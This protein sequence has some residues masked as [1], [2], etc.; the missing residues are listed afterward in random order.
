M[1]KIRL[2]ICSLVLA[3]VMFCTSLESVSGADE[4]Q[5]ETSAEKITVSSIE[6]LVERYGSTDADQKTVTIYIPQEDTVYVTNVLR[7]SAQFTPG[8]TYC[9]TGG[10]VLKQDESNWNRPMISLSGALG[11]GLRLEL[12]NI[13][14]DGGNVPMSGTET[15]LITI[16]GYD[17]CVTMEQDAGARTEIRNFNG[18]STDSSAVCAPVIAEYGAEF[19]LNGGTI[20]DNTAVGE[21]GYASGGVLLK[22]YGLGNYPNNTKF[23]M[24]GGVIKD[25]HGIYGA[26]CV[27]FPH[28]T[29]TMNGGSICDNTSR[30]GGGIYYDG[31]EEYTNALP[32]PYTVK[33]H[34]NASMVLNS[35]TISGNQAAV[36]GNSIYYKYGDPI[37]LGGDMQIS[38]DVYLASGDVTEQYF[39]LTDTLAYPLFLTYMASASYVYDGR[40]IARGDGSYVPTPSDADQFNLSNEGFAPEYD[41][42]DFCIKLKKKICSVTWDVEGTVTAETYEYAARPKYGGS[43]EKRAD[44]EYVY[45]FTG[46]KNGDGLFYGTDTVLPTVK[47]DVTYTAQYAYKTYKEVFLDAVNTIASVTYTYGCKD[48]LEEANAAYNA[49]TDEMKQDT[50]IEGAYERLT[51]FLHVWTTLGTMYDLPD[52]ITRKSGTAIQ[53]SRASFDQLSSKEKGM[54]AEDAYTKL[55]RAE[56]VYQQLL[57]VQ[58]VQAAKNAYQL[59]YGKE[60]VRLTVSATGNGTLHYQSSDT[61]IVTVDDNGNLKGTGVGTAYVTVY[62]DENLWFD[63][64]S[65]EPVPVTVGKGTQSITVKSVYQSDGFL[66]Q[67][68][69]SGGGNLT[70]K[71]TDSSVA[72]VD[73]YGY[74]HTKGLGDVSITVNAAE[75]KLYQ[76]A[77]KTIHLEIAA[78]DS[79]IYVVGNVK[80]QVTN[81]ETNGTG[82]V[83]VV[84]LKNPKV[85]TV[86]IGSKVK[87]GNYE[88]KITG[89]AAEAFSK[90]LSLKNVTLG[91][92]LTQIGSKAFYGCK[93]LSRLTVS[94]AKF[95]KA[96]NDAIRGSNKKLVICVPEGK[97]T[98]YGKYFNYAAGY[99]AGMKI[100]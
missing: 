74:V 87:L 21:F 47:S 20:H 83:S 31:R 99:R 63:E 91:S 7:L 41:G 6:E 72:V 75:T 93:N 88:Y 30:F 55:T 10:G 57:R 16:Y 70:Y 12:N 78:K 85:S 15:A 29:F 44:S 90:N 67:C 37:V 56:K 9:L 28:C 53:A 51:S 64:A 35:G 40:S 14:V 39:I 43:T 33:Y 24:N 84:G 100:K 95:K 61:S 98:E 81:A 97:V 60:G 5:T 26:V 11:K 3:V 49:L 80:Y 2:R 46:W 8:Y 1:G 79:Y 32:A 82:C 68:K 76:S 25:N 42:S 66:L 96:G 38:D 23:T 54:V 62:A 71:S 36:Y 58:T 65:S 17:T 22:G 77:Q 13:I 27:S 92:N 50:E 52:S 19:E 34:V 89:I 73:S 4:G 59:T 18:T 45:F 69:S 94:C 86:R 48:E